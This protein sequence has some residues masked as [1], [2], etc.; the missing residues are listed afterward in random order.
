V[1]KASRQAEQGA[2]GEGRGRFQ[3]RGRDPSG[4]IFSQNASGKTTAF[5][6]EQ[7]N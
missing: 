5:N 2:G 4:Y 7:F 3:L 1:K 6:Y